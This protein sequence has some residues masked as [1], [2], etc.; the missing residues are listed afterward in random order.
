MDCGEDH[1]RRIHRKSRAGCTSCKIRHIRCDEFKPKCRN[2]AKR[3]SQCHYSSSKRSLNEKAILDIPWQTVQITESTDWNPEVALQDDQPYPD[4]SE[5]A[6]RLPPS[7]SPFSLSNEDLRLM[8]HLLYVSSNLETSNSSNLLTWTSQIPVFVEL[9]NT[10]E[11]VRY[12]LL[13]L[14]ASHLGWLTRSSD[15][16]NVAARHQ[17][18]AYSSLQHAV[19]NFTKAN[20]DAIFAASI[21]L[22]WQAQ[23]WRS[24]AALIKG[25]TAVINAMRPWVSESIFAAPLLEHIQ[26]AD[27]TRP[28]LSMPYRPLAGESKRLK[29]CIDSLHR[30]ENFMT[31]TE[32]HSQF[33]KGLLDF[34][35]NLQNFPPGPSASEQFK[36][37][38]PLRGWLFWLP[39]SFLQME[40]KDIHVLVCFAFYNATVL[41]VKP[42][43]PAVGA[44]FYRNT[45][46]TAIRQIY[47]YL[48]SVQCKVEMNGEGKNES[49][50]EA[51]DLV[52]SC[53]EIAS[54]HWNEWG[55]DDLGQARVQEEYSVGLSLSAGSL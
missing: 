16:D 3:G 37:V 34:T 30:A 29:L 23:D 20:A 18:S 1:A 32:E 21:I 12:S 17:T 31:T 22:S 45:Q 2:C 40:K 49:L 26:E 13:S 44:V 50:V 10:H 51:L 6:V 47:Y 33:H 25:E 15:L 42:F 4:S 8:H 41:A 54:E 5:L 53:M 43:F 27:H 19:N 24:W 55:H 46:T 38:Y 7:P 39:R 52:G 28:I 35:R 11:I 48:L 36:L 14:S 9:S